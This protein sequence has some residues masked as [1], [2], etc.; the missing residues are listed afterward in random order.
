MG[1]YL[2]IQADLRNLGCRPHRDLESER[3]QSSHTVTFKAVGYQVF[4]MIVAEFSAGGFPCGRSFAAW[5]HS[6]INYSDE[7][8]T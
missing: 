3:F 7:V 5:V 2:K 4:D 6:V 8:L 1:A